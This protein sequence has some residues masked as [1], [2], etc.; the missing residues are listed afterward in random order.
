MANWIRD[1]YPGAVNVGTQ[2]STQPGNSISSSSVQNALDSLISDGTIITIP[3][4]NQYSGNGSNT[5]VRVS[6]FAG[7]RITGYRATG[8]AHQRYV[9]G[10]FV[11]SLCNSQCRSGNGNSSAGGGVAKIRLVG[12]A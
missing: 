7:F 10:Y 6:G 8:K 2:Y 4:Y 3:L 5:Q 1:G 12:G 9:E 11:K